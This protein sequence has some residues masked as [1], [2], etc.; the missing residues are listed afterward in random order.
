VAA[1]TQ[2]LQEREQ[3]QRVMLGATDQSIILLDLNG[4]ILMANEIAAKRMNRS[5]K[6]F[7]G[8]CVYDLLPPELARSRK[9]AVKRV[10][11][12]GKPV[13]FEDERDGIIME[14]NLFPI[15]NLAGEV[16]RI[17]IFAR[18]I[19]EQK[20]TEIA[21]QASEEKYR[22]LAEASHDMIFVVNEDDQVEY[23]NSFAADQFNL[24][25][26]DLV[27]KPQSVL[28]PGQIATRQR[29]AIIAA[30]AS[31]SPKYSEDWVKFGKGKDAYISTWLVPL[32]NQ[33][34]G[35]R[36]VLGV[37]RDI[38]TI[39]RMQEELKSSHDQLERRVEARTKE[40]S[41]LSAAMRMLAQ[42]VITAQEEER[43][44]ISR[45][46]HDDIGQVLVTLKYSLAELLKEFPTDKGTFHQKVSEEIK[47]VD[48]AMASIRS[49]SHS[50]RPP[51]LDAGGLN[52]SLKDFCKD[53]NRRTQMDVDYEGVEL[54]NLPDDMAVTLFRFVQEAF[55]N[56]FKHSRATRV[57]VTLQYIR[58]RIILSISDNG[59]GIRD[60]QDSSGI[61]LIGIRERVGYLG[62][63]LQ[64]KASPG[65]GTIIKA[66]I[67][68]KGPEIEA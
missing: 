41:D 33:S 59:V 38:T 34:N 65:K 16:D 51:L 37:S 25:S 36:S 30:I 58:S 57:S 10:V 55:S 14:S 64:I 35:K 56:I 12:T 26:E 24:K 7:I 2:E 66:S 17:V 63:K 8:V 50:L 32:N 19:T 5:L 46:L 31:G 52:I 40:L 39:Q 9:S 29:E 48:E 22:L 53:I 44:R 45:E 21:L 23:V 62:G 11:H 67:P 13:L 3:I 54:D 1:K 47:G 4:V 43:R 60:P 68:W 42:K 28:F 61:G 20:R 15:Y 27:G 18:D 49:I 6:D